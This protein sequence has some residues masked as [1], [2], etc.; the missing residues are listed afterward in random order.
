MPLF[1]YFLIFLF[2]IKFISCWHHRWYHKPNEYFGQFVN[3]FV[4]IDCRTPPSDIALDT[5]PAMKYSIWPIH[6]SLHYPHCRPQ[7]VTVLH[8]DMQP[9]YLVYY[10]MKY[11]P[12]MIE[13][14]HESMIRLYI[15]IFLFWLLTSI[16]LLKVG[17]RFILHVGVHIHSPLLQYLSWYLR[18]QI[19]LT[20]VE[21]NDEYGCID[22]I[23]NHNWNC[24]PVSN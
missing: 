2:F 20:Y 4:P 10:S 15:Y 13:M 18:E 19:Q 7:M 24:F 17:K 5:E 8:C 11:Y 22:Q 21:Q 3:W 1:S 16:L 6:T 12:N 23:G 14:L 9:Y